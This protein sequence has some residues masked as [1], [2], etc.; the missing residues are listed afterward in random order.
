MVAYLGGLKSILGLVAMS[1]RDGL[2]QCV[3]AAHYERASGALGS[4]SPPRRIG[5]A[6]RTLLTAERQLDSNANV[7]LCVE[8]FLIRLARLC[9]AD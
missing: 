3:G 4:N 8:G 9:R 5:D 7:Q 1:L 2:T 6:I